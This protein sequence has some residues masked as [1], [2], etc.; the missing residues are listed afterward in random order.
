ML[1][2]HLAGVASSAFA[3]IFQSVTAAQRVKLAMH[4]FGIIVPR[5]RN[6]GDQ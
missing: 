2:Q 5:K 6:H 1:L 3:K 4:L